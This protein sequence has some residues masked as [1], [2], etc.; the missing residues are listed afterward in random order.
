MTAEKFAKPASDSTKTEVEKIVQSAPVT[1][2]VG[3]VD[4]DNL[5]SG[6]ANPQEDLLGELLSWLRKNKQMSVLMM[7]RQVE[8]LGVENG[9]AQLFSEKADLGELITNE[10]YKQVL[11]EFF[12]S[13]NLS[14]KIKEKQKHIDPLGEL[15]EMFGEK[16]I[17][18]SF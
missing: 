5:K 16:L 7:C 17:V 8:T 10:S 14:Y 4:F 11:D 18:K 9:V 2:N 6:Q 3:L 12:K 15:K 1:E 13:K